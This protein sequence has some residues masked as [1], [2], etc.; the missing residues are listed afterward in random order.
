MSARLLPKT[1][2]GE[3]YV[4]AGDPA[5]PAR[6]GRSATATSSPQDRTQHRG[7]ARAGPRRPAAAAAGDPAG[8]L[9]ATLGAL[10]TALR[11]AATQ[12]G[13]QP[14]R[15]STTTCAQL[16][17]QLPTLQ[18]RH[19]RP[20]RRR[21]TSTPTPRPTCSRSLRNLTV[22]SR[23]PSSSS[24][25]AGRL[26]GRHHGRRDTTAHVP[27][28]QR[29]PDHPARRESAGP[30][31][32]AGRV[33]ARV[34]VPAA[35]GLVDAAARGSTRCSADERRLHIT[36]EII[37]SDHGKYLPGATSRARREHRGPSCR[38]LPNP[39]GPADATRAT[40]SPTATHG[41]RR[42]ADG[43]CHDG[44]PAADGRPPARRR[45]GD[46]LRGHRRGAGP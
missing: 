35:Q 9:A 26:P 24:G 25:P 2:F 7:R 11:A 1:L 27:D 20:G 16:N 30:C 5:G 32:T 18:R 33:R 8:P 46:G 3:R 19:R 40:S 43:G 36:L 45:P 34:P 38:G 13:R 28:E 39:A 6:A 17:P 10:A 4:D 31:W 14:G 44:A 29:R 42:P 37:R 41:S 22:T 23:R 12:L 15:S 21:S